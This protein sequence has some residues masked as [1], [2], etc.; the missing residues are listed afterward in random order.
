MSE[1]VTDSLNKPPAILEIDRLTVRYPVPGGTIAVVDGVNLRID[2]G[3]TFGLIGETGAGK[4]LTAWAAIDLVPPPGRVT[5]GEVRWRGRRLT[6]LAEAEVRKVRGDEIAIITQN[7]QAALNPMKSIGD[8]I[9]AAVVA[10]RA[11]SRRSAWDAAIAQLRAVGLPN[12]ERQMRSYPHQLSGGMA[13]RALI[14]LALVNQ[15]RL[16]IAD[17]PTTGLDMTIQAEIL[18]LMIRLVRDTGAAIWLITHDLGVIANYTERASVMFG[19]QIV[20]AA[21]TK[22]L[23]ENPSHPYTQLLLE[24]LR[25]DAPQAQAATPTAHPTHSGAGCRFAHRC[26]WVETPCLA[27]Q[28]SLSTIASDHRVRC[29]VAERLA[30]EA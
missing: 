1:N 21:S 9:V 19:G 27:D 20:E 7:P 2:A 14:A 18:D 6:G 15:P 26:P 4:S 23:F 22:T 24:V 12:P 10:H 28:P 25:S 30:K 3:E 5:E 17:E 8:Q 11:M 29:F 16:L 13:Q